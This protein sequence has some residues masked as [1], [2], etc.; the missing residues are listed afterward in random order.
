MSSLL[1]V[2]SATGNQKNRSNPIHGG[3][4]DELGCAVYE[5]QARIG[6]QSLWIVVVKQDEF[7]G[8]LRSG[9]GFSAIGKARVHLSRFPGNGSCLINLA[10]AFRLDDQLA[11]G[12][13]WARWSCEP[14]IWPEGTIPLLAHQGMGNILMDFGSFAAAHDVFRCADP[15]GRNPAILFHRSRALLGAGQL[16]QAWELAEA[17][18]DHPAWCEGL[19]HKPYWLDWSETFSLTLWDEQ[20]FGDTLQALRWLPELPPRFS[21]MTIQVRAPLQRLLVAGLSW[22]GDALRVTQRPVEP[23]SRHHEGCHGSLLSLPA[24]TAS[25]S[26]PSGQVLRLPSVG[27]RNGQFQI[28]LVWEAGRYCHDPAKELE[29]RRKSLPASIRERMCA[30]LRSRD[31]EV[32][33]VQPGYDLPAK[34]DFLEQARLI[35]RCNLLISVDTAA[36][37]LGGAIGHPTWLLLPWAAASRW[38]REGQSTPLYSSMRLFRQPRHQD[39]DAV[40][41]AVLEAIDQELV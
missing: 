28:G 4:T 20:G 29:F 22:M 40:L 1:M 37:H 35:Q 7:M 30:E 6:L 19:P 34:A 8:E 12:L 11:D 31:V 27:L 25:S 21:C 24:R 38:G 3:F 9:T 26:W 17:R 14:S 15:D 33:L 2:E 13:S 10:N 39:W 32:Q 16:R 5:L 41:T 36:A 18:L 23:E